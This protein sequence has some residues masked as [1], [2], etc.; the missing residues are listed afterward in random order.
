MKKS[1][2]AALAALSVAALAPGEVSAGVPAT[3]S[4]PTA[5][6]ACTRARI[7]GESRCIAAGQF[8]RHRRSANRDYHRYGYRC[9]KRD[10]GGRYHLVRR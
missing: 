8:C 2:A 1:L 6:A 3:A 5:H 4:S 10:S 9:G 7:E